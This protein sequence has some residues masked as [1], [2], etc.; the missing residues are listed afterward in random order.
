MRFLALDASVVAG[1]LLRL[2]GFE[3][4]R[5][6]TCGKSSTGKTTSVRMAASVWRSGAEPP[7]WR[8]TANGLE[9]ELARASDGLLMLDEMG[10][11]DQREFAASI[12]T[13]ASGVGRARMRRDTSL[14]DPLS[15]LALILSSGE[16]VIETRL[17]E[18][19]GRKA[20]AGPDQ[21]Q[22]AAR[23]LCRFMARSY[24]VVGPRCYAR[25]F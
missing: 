9:G 3:G 6:H 16:T 2:V 21:F 13:A 17:G 8:A 25:A 14:R 4:R 24:H 5:R 11:S 23:G 18:E 10:Q 15:W 19:R 1:R 22:V 7:T 12:Y 20:R